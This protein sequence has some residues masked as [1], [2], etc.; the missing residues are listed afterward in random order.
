MLEI[1]EKNLKSI[2]YS[3]SFQ[4]VLSVSNSLSYLDYESMT[5]LVEKLNSDLFDKPFIIITDNE[6]D[7]P[8]EANFSNIEIKKSC[9]ETTPY[10]LE[11]TFLD[12]GQNEYLT[13]WQ[14]IF[15]GAK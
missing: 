5:N 12:D 2:E 11:I 10:D 15:G 13:K 7:N 8:F 3:Q 6:P 14:N 9:T 4:T 1:I